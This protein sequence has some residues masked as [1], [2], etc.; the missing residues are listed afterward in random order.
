MARRKAALRSGDSM[1]LILTLV[2]VVMAV[3]TAV[4]GLWGLLVINAQT[5]PLSVLDILSGLIG[6]YSGKSPQWQVPGVPLPLPYRI[7]EVLGPL[8]TGYAVVSAGAV[9]LTNQLR[10]LRARLARQH[11][12]VCGGD[13]AGVGLARSLAQRRTAVLVAPEAGSEGTGAALVRRVIPISGD[14]RDPLVLRRA[15]IARADEVF[16]L[17]DSDDVNASIT[18]ATSAAAKGRKAPLR[19]YALVDD[20]DL[21]LT[22][23]ART[24]TRD[25]HPT[26]TL[27][28]LDRHQLYASAV[29]D[30]ESAALGDTTIVVGSGP[31]AYALATEIARV[32]VDRSESGPRPHRVR[33]SGADSAECARAITARWP[34][35]RHLIDVAVL[36]AE[37]TDDVLAGS[38]QLAVFVSEAE[39]DRETLHTGLAWLHRSGSIARVVLCMAADSGLTSAFSPEENDLFVDAGSVLRV[40]S[41]I[42][43]LS[44]PEHLRSQTL[45]ERLARRLHLIYRRE[46]AQGKAAGGT[47]LVADRPWSQLPELLQDSNRAQA[48]DLGNKLTAAG[49][50]ITP[51]GLHRRGAIGFDDELTERLAVLEHERWMAERLARG[52]RYGPE[53]TDT[54]HPDLVPWNEL[55][56]IAREKDRVFVRRIPEMLRAEGFETIANPM[57]RHSG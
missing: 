7:A 10:L 3:G 26:I 11:S 15:G 12:I 45:A 23:Q 20:R 57:S 32:L 46:V 25:A 39:G 9:L 38:G 31:T 29:L 55:S 53:R 22:L 16:A 36:A 42:V 33:L 43:G 30:R 52:I 35:D 5:M 17:A 28:L 34:V 6:L 37:E 4:L 1:V 44:D 8:S 41:P 13:R 19:C 2:F 21:H 40:Y 56:E 47:P 48:T 14:P 49:L 27:H 54:E 24:I 51:I 18:L 50:A